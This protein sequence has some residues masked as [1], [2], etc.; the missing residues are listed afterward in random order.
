MGVGVER[1]GLAVER[2]VVFP[3]AENS[4]VTCPGL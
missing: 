4:S 3:G 1:T 2:G